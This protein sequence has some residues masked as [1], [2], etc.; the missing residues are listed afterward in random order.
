[1]IQPVFEELAR[2]KAKAPGGGQRVAFVKVDLGVGMGLVVAR[3]YGVAVTPTYGFFFGWEEGAWV[4]LV[5]DFLL[6]RSV[7]AR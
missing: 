5:F 6:L 2:A 7:L 4:D 1:M 3:E